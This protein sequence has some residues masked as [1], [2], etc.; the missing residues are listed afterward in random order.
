MR[1]LEK[2][3]EVNSKEMKMKIT[4][5]P[6]CTV[7]VRAT[8]Y[9]MSFRE[10]A[11]VLGIEIADIESFG[12]CGYP[13][14]AVSELSALSMAAYN[15]Q[16]AEKANLPLV[17]LCSACSGFLKEVAFK[18]ES[19]DKLRGEINKILL[20]INPSY[21]Y[22][23][24]TLVKHVARFLVE[25]IGVEEITKKI[26][27]PLKDIKVAI[28]YGCHFVRPRKLGYSDDPENPES[29]DR[30]VHLT[31]AT[32]VPYEGLMDCC[33]GGILGIKEDSAL[34]IAKRKLDSISAIGVDA[35]VLICPF[36]SVMFEGNQKKIEKIAGKTYEIP[37][38]YY[39]QLLGLAFGL[40]AERLG[41]S[42]NRIKAKTILDKI[43]SGF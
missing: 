41:F 12:C 8:N 2:K 21:S 37:V 15:L 1:I 32:P 4:L 34:L 5:F 38:L 6:G 22:N 36:C 20:Q 17:T 26:V 30:L 19:D 31:G 13:M 3:N 23:G 35:I 9:E 18:L 33:G 39:T 42:M 10:V 40:D 16:M 7:P 24:S 27:R 28:H 29:L 14:M 43:L 25:D 11:G